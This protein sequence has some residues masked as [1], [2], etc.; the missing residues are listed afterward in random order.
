MR[1]SS[2]VLAHW[3]LFKVFL[4]VDVACAHVLVFLFSS[5]GDLVVVF[6]NSHLFSFSYSLVPYYLFIFVYLY[7]F[8]LNLVFSFSLFTGFGM[9]V[10]HMFVIFSYSN[11]ILESVEFFSLFYCTSF[12]LPQC[13]ARL[14]YSQ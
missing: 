6:A 7:S 10:L 2:R 8:P 13:F 4:D 3:F 11:L 12:F 1:R 5:V 9:A 14:A